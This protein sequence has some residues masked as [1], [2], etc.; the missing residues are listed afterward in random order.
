MFFACEVWCIADASS[1]SPSSEQLFLKLVFHYLSAYLL[2]C[3]Y[4]SLSLYPICFPV[5]I[6]LCLPILSASLFVYLS[7]SLSY[8][9]PCLYISLSSYP[10]CFPVCISLCLPILSIFHMH[11]YQTL[12]NFSPYSYSFAE[13][14]L[15]IETSTFHLF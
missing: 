1:V 2:P 8:L 5:C 14:V 10:I 9:L 12:N 3:L 15:K 11:I 4:I 13:K 7:V 6:S